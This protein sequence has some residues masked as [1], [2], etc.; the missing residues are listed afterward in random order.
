M[1]W[2]NDLENDANYKRWPA[3]VMDLLRP[4]F[5]GMFRN[6]RKNLFNIILLIDPITTEARNIIR[7]AESFVIHLAPIRL[8]IVF[9]NRKGVD[10]LE[11][12][13]RAILCAFNYVAQKNTPREALSFLTDVSLFSFFFFIFVILINQFHNNYNM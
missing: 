6:I 1:T 2:I 4:T 8:G 11:T 12:D 9:D 7:L 3:S 10:A 13:Y 5:P